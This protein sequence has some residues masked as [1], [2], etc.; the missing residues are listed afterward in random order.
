MGENYLQVSFASPALVLDLLTFIFR[1]SFIDH[2]NKYPN[3]ME[4]F[5]RTSDFSIT[6]PV[7]SWTDL[8][9]AMAELPNEVYMNRNALLAFAVYVQSR[10][11]D[12]RL[13]VPSMP[14]FVA[15]EQASS[16]I[17]ASMSVAIFEA[18]MADITA[19]NVSNK[20]FEIER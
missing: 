7:C 17:A 16:D 5:Y 8:F 6:A 15:G 4:G 12:K 13:D 20:P 18:C 3:R 1:L 10:N 19:V 11:L 9:T 14:D 2:W